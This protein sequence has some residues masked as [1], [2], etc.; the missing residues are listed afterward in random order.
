[1]DSEPASSPRASWQKQVPTEVQRRCGRPR[2]GNDDPRTAAG[3]RDDGFQGR[4]AARCGYRA[5][6]ARAGLPGGR[7]AARA[8][9]ATG[10][11][12]GAAGAACQRQQIDPNGRKDPQRRKA[13]DRKS[14]A[15]ACRQSARDADGVRCA[16]RQRCRSRSSLAANPT[17]RAANEIFRLGGVRRIRADPQLEEGV[18]GH[19]VPPNQQITKPGRSVRAASAML[20]HVAIWLPDISVLEGALSARLTAPQTVAPTFQGTNSFW[21]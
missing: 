9:A 2:D 20:L 12:A 8:S 7:V 1:M 16:R 21:P 17:H 13:G 14:N 18:D 4:T 10:G 19:G 3:Q 5:L 11:F 6:S 15:S